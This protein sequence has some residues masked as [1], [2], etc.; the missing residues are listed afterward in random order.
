VGLVVES[1]PDEVGNVPETVG[2]LHESIGARTTFAGEFAEIDE[3]AAADE[4]GK[5]GPNLAETREGFLSGEL[6]HGEV[7]EDEADALS[8]RAR[9]FER[10]DPIGSLEDLVAEFRKQFASDVAD[11]GLVV[12]EEN[13][14]AVV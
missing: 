8:L 9:E 3:E 14:F 5:L 4:D 10:L 2:L 13:G 12:N 7:E 1:V 11:V 6:R